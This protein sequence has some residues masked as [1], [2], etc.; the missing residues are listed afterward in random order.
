MGS[1]QFG[2]TWRAIVA[3]TTASLLAVG[4][5]PDVETEVAPTPE[6]TTAEA[7]TAESE[8]TPS[9][10]P[11]VGVPDG[12]LNALLIGTDSR[13]EGDL[14]GNADTIMLAHLPEDRSAIYLISF[15]RDMWVDIP[16]LGEGKINSA[17]S[18]GGTETLSATVSDVLGGVE[19]DYVLQTTFD[20]FIAMTRALDGIP[21]ENQHHSTVT[22]GSTGRV[23]D[24]PEGSIVLENTD[25]LI[26]VRERKRLPLGDL[27]RAERQRAAVTGMMVKLASFRDDPVKLAEVM[28]YM[29]GNVKIT[30]QFGSAT[31]LSLV[32]MADDL[33]PE[34]V[35]SL[36]VPL[37]GFGNKNGASVNLV[38]EAQ[39]A[40]LGQALRDDAMPGYVETYGTDYAP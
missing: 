7:A 36:M 14:T 25:G 35:V 21:V 32:P 34:D 15:T 37:T 4:C 9:P 26:Y 28:G 24:F 5:S 13:E 33:T 12:A 2:R 40:A 20:G 17:F 3:I 39:T 19:I 38:D 8:P 22:V 31:A 30:G 1:A 23:V 18:R 27:D 10:T 6:A 16:G 11:T 29:I